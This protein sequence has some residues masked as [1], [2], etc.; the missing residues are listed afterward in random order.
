MTRGLG[1][2][3]YEWNQSMVK[4]GLIMDFYFNLFCL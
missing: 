4:G 3:K 2:T 1:P